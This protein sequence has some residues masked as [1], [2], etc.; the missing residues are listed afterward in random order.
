MLVCR[1]ELRSLQIERVNYSNIDLGT[2]Y[3]IS[4]PGPKNVSEDVRSAVKTSPRETSTVG[5]RGTI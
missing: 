1:V 3:E 5:M 4:D 2:R